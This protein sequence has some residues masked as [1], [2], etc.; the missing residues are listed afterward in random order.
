M[1]GPRRVAIVGRVLGRMQIVGPQRTEPNPSPGEPSAAG[2]NTPRK[3]GTLLAQEQS[4]ISTLDAGGIGGFAWG[5]EGAVF[6]AVLDVDTLSPAAPPST[7]TEVFDAHVARVHLSAWDAVRASRGSVDVAVGRDGSVVLALRVLSPEWGPFRNATVAV[8]NS[9]PRLLRACAAGGAKVGT[10]VLRLAAT[11]LAVESTLFI[12][13]GGDGAQDDVQD[14]TVARGTIADG[15][16][17]AIA[18]VADESEAQSGSG[19]GNSGVDDGSQDIT[20]SVVARFPPGT[21]SVGR[22]GTAINLVSLPLENRA[23]LPTL[24]PGAAACDRPHDVG[25][26]RYTTVGEAMSIPARGTGS[27][28]NIPSNP[29]HIGRT[30]WAMFA[31]V[32]IACSLAVGAA[33]WVSRPGFAGGD[34]ELENAIGDALDEVDGDE[35][36]QLIHQ[37]ARPFDF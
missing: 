18:I 27:D 19:G 30:G 16:G 35:V 3:L 24:P 15:G 26:C 33:V 34:P 12:P 2:D 4:S 7:S 5:F 37:A 11:G 31:I 28:G 14:S 32:G 1:A 13:D 9:A 17:V 8:G 21:L 36:V 6:A 10:F 20:L 22:G 29:D 25:E 23:P